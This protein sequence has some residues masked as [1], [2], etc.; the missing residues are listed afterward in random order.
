MRRIIFANFFSLGKRR[1]SPLGQRLGTKLASH[2]HKEKVASESNQDDLAVNNLTI[3]Q[4]ITYGEYNNTLSVCR[5]VN[6][7]S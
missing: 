2:M 1:L 4:S 5:S 3:N 7:E 6:E